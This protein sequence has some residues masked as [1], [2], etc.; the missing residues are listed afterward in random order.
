VYT[1]HSDEGLDR[2]KGEKAKTP[3]QNG[4]DL[5]ERKESCP[6]KGGLGKARIECEKAGRSPNYLGGGRENDTGAL[7]LK[8]GLVRQ[9][10]D[11]AGC[12]LRRKGSGECSEYG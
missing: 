9:G 10:G 4:S 11:F 8:E 7:T 3:N 6:M 5:R 12:L 1:S 2:K